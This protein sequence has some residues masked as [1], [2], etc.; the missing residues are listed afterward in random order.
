L[1][2]E[3]T[4]SGWL[5]CN[6]FSALASR[7]LHLPQGLSVD[8]VRAEHSSFRCAG[9]DAERITALGHAVHFLRDAGHW[10]HTDNP[11]G[12]LK[13]MEPAFGPNREDVRA[14]HARHSSYEASVRV[15]PMQVQ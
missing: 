2:G 9:E 7:S 11:Q 13:I 6:W 5:L 1:I 14:M 15:R 8:F 10:V 4:H 3:R 12:L